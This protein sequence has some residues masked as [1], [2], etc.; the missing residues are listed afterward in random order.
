MFETALLGEVGMGA[1]F[2]VAPDGG[3]D[4]RHVATPSARVCAPFVSPGHAVHVG[5]RRS[6]TVTTGLPDGG[7]STGP[8]RRPV[9]DLLS[10]LAFLHGRL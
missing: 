6:F 4:F 1:L 10:D 5:R 7:P 2:H 3:G 8:I 9:R